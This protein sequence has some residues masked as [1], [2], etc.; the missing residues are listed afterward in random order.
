MAASGSPLFSTYNPSGAF[1]VVDQ[2]FTTGNIW[3]VGSATGTN[4]EGYGKSPAAPFATIDYAVGQAT[5][6][7]GD[8]IY[9]MPYHAETVS[10]AGGA[11]Q[12]NGV[13]ATACLISQNY[14]GVVSEDL[15][16][17][18]DPIAT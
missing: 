5:A 14:Y 17:I 13:T 11:A 4:G 7:N 6:S 12:A 1:T 15:S 2:S 8:V 16:A 10:A 3:F 9:V 18:L